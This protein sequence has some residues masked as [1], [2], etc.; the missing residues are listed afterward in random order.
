MPESLLSFSAILLFGRKL[1]DLAIVAS[2]TSDPDLTEDAVVLTKKDLPDA[3]ANVRVKGI[4][5]K[6]DEKV[7]VKHKSDAAQTGLWKLDKSGSTWTWETG[8][9]NGANASVR[10]LHAKGKHNGYWN[11]SVSATGVS[12]VKRIKS[13]GRG[14]NNFLGDQLDDD[15]RFARIYGFSY[16]GDYF[17]LPSPT[18][19]LVHGDGD[20]VSQDNNTG[21]GQPGFPSNLS[22]A[23]RDP[24]VGGMA[25][26]DFQFADDIRVWDYDK[27]DYTIRMDVATG[28]FEQVLLDAT[29]GD[30][31]FGVSGA[32]VSGAKVSGAKVSGAKV[33]G[34]KVS[35]AK[36]RGP[37]D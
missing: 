24:S 30:G 21:T 18:L 10:V 9:P 25:A 31:G 16:E 4:K 22:R 11:V 28:M 12:T 26:A 34:A 20:L 1:D 3:E 27:A 5:I 23:P 7:L 2:D 35:G 36:A 32:K 8:L 37:G 33:S 13:T 17:D 29:L 6:E 19:F 14:N 15:A